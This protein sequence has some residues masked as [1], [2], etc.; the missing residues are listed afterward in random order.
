MLGTLLSSPWTTVSLRQL[1]TKVIGGRTRPDFYHLHHDMTAF[2]I[3]ENFYD[4]SL[5]FLT[6]TLSEKE[7]ERFLDQ[8]KSKGFD[9]CSAGFSE[10]IHKSFYSYMNNLSER[11]KGEL[12]DIP[13]ID[14]PSLRWLDFAGQLN[15][16]V[17]LS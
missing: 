9:P 14:N 11:Y 12:A 17:L 4:A 5:S 15:K 2:N 13:D 7:K 8:A 6:G 10:Q 3:K 16:R 1:H